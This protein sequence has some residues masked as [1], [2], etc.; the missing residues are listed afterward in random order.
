MS[1][2]NEMTEYLNRSST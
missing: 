2:K 1:E